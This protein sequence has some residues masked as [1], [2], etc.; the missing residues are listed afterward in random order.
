VKS[1]TSRALARLRGRLGVAI[2]VAVAVALIAAVPAARTAVADVVTMSSTSPGRDPQRRPADVPATP[3]PLRSAR[4]VSLD[5]ARRLAVP[6]GVPTRTRPAG[7]GVG[8]R[9]GRRRL[10]AVVSLIFRGGAVRVDE[11]AG[12][13]ELSFVKMGGD[14]SYVTVHGEAAIWLAEP[15]ALT[16]VDSTGVVRTA[17]TR[18]A[19]PTLLWQDDTV[20]TGSRA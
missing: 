5:E 8:L 13:F 20:A 11:Y 3:E 12:T 14:I 18:L 10:A 4:T 2:A 16:Y 6:V 15:H 1:R 19:G 9:P 7:G 17:T